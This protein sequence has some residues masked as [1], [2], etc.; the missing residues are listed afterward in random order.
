MF[1]AH[2]LAVKLVAFALFFFKYRVA[3]GFEFAKTFFEPTRNAAIK[4]HG[5]T[6]EIF[7]KASIMT[8]E[9]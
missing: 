9:N 2:N 6:R 4:P 5:R 8:D 1:L 3:P 7:E